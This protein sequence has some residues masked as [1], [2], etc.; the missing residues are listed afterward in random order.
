MRGRPR[1]FPQPQSSAAREL[2]SSANA[3]MC[4]KCKPCVISEI[5]GELL[6]PASPCPHPWL[7]SASVHLVE[8]LCIDRFTGKSKLQNL[9]L[10]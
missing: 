1:P 2:K 6:G 10:A 5:C 3:K 8:V 9:D 7:E 4:R